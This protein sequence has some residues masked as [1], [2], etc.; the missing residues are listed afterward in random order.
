MPRFAAR[1]QTVYLTALPYDEVLRRLHALRAWRRREVE[2]HQVEAFELFR[3]PEREFRLS[4]SAL[5]TRVQRNA[6]RHA[7]AMTGEPLR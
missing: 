2:P 1:A 7:E 3:T 6:R 4:E 5:W